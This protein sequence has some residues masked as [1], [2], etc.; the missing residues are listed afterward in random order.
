MNPTQSANQ[1]SASHEE[2]E[3]SKAPSWPIRSID[4]QSYVPSVILLIHSKLLK[5]IFVVLHSKYFE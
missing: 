4:W 3:G 1:I 2:I 5:E